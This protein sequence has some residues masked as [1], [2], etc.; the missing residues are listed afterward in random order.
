YD[1]EYE[2]LYMNPGACGVHGFHKV[3][4]ALQFELV[5]KEVKNLS[6]IELGPRSSIK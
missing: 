2:L 4:T 6:V 5:N 1:K 3:K